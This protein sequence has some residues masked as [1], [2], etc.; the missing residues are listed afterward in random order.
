MKEINKIEYDEN[1]LKGTKNKMFS[2]LKIIYSQ[3]K[4]SLDLDRSFVHIYFK[5]QKV[6]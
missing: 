4:C 6:F 1:R 5:T 3:F 2:S